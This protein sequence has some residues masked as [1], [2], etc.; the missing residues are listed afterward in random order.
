MKFFARRVGYR[1]VH[2]TFTG[3]S[4]EANIITSADGKRNENDGQSGK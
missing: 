1:Y 4:I 3:K 2:T